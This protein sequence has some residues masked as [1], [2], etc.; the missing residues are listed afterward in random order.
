[1]LGVSY[2]RLILIGKDFKNLTEN[3]EVETYNTVCLK[4][5]LK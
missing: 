1:M 4:S 3:S 2:L 5:A